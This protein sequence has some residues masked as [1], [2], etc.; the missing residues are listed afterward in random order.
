MWQGTYARSVLSLTCVKR[1]WIVIRW[2]RKKVK[3]TT[4]SRS[5]YHVYLT[6]IKL[7]FY[8]FFTNKLLKN[9]Y[10]IH[11]WVNGIKFTVILVYKINI[12][13]WR[14]SSLKHYFFLKFSTKQ[15][16]LYHQGP[17][18]HTVGSP[19]LSVFILAYRTVRY[20]V[21]CGTVR[22]AR[23]KTDFLLKLLNSWL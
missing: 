12:V 16:L 17:W 5:I 14:D 3:L 23:I 18:P 22:Y 21:Y 9:Y 6:K 7:M 8:L 19:I 2:L 13:V 20:T 10:V 1:A 15:Y 11:V 4:M